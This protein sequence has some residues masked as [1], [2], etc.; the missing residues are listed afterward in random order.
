MKRRQLFMRCAPGY[1]WT[2]ACWASASSSRRRQYSCF[3]ISVR[4]VASSAGIDAGEVLTPVLLLHCRRQARAVEMDVGQ[5][6]RHGAAL[7]DLL[8]FVQQAGAG[9]G[10]GAQ[11]AVVERGGE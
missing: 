9:G 4:A 6:E 2:A 3:S 10:I 1:Q 7:G 5:I 8:S 11:R